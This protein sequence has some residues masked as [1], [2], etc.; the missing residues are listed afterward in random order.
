MQLLGLMAQPQRAQ[1]FGHSALPMLYKGA[2]N[3]NGGAGPTAGG[4]CCRWPRQNILMIT[5]TASPSPALAL[6]QREQ[7]KA[8][9]CLP[10]SGL[11]KACTHRAQ[12]SA[13]WPRQPCPGTPQPSG[14]LR[15]RQLWGTLQSIL[16]R[17]ALGVTGPG[18][19]SIRASGALYMAGA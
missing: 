7:S 8:F 5:T 17:T 19:A 2:G 15:C 12:T 4:C 6:Q 14:A 1:Q 11:G 16:L 9:T 13:P 3:V 18:T 10:S